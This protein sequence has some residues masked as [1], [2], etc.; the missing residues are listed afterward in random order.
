MPQRTQWRGRGHESKGREG[1]TAERRSRADRSNS[2]EEFRLLERAIG[3][4]R[5]RAS[6]NRGG[7]TPWAKA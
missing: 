4:D 3:H 6:S 2:G 7:G 5:A 1:R